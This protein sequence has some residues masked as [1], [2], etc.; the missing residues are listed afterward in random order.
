MLFKSSKTRISLSFVAVHFKWSIRYMNKSSAVAETGNP[1]HTCPHKW[2]KKWG[3]ALPLSL[4]GAGS[5]SN[6]MSPG[7][8]PTSIPSGIPM[9][10]AVWPQQTWPK[11]GGGGY[12]ALSKGGSWLG[13]H[14][15]QCY[16][17]QGS[18]SSDILIHPAVWPQQTWAEKWG[19][20]LCP[21]F[22]WGK[23]VTH[24]T[25]CRLG[26]GLPAYQVAS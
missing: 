8:R 10:A 4:G 6:T 1:G 19:R 15:M 21:F 7:P 18:V 5:P 2:A 17:G 3:A 16:M 22:G 9:H 14:L 25:H 20:L 24:L 23:L 26:R 13:P 11:S 12:C